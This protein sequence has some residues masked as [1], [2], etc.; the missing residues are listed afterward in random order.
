MTLLP[1]ASGIGGKDLVRS[2]GDPLHV[3][4]A[5]RGAHPGSKPHEDQV[6]AVQVRVRAP[7]GS[8]ERGR[9]DPCRRTALRCP[10]R[11]GRRRSCC[12]PPPGTWR[13][14][15]S[16]SGWAG[17]R[18]GRP[19]GPVAR[20]R[21]CRRRACASTVK[22]GCDPSTIWLLASRPCPDR[23]GG[24]TCGMRAS[25]EDGDGLAVDL[26][27]GVVDAASRRRRRGRGSSSVRACGGTS[28]L[29]LSA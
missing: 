11:C 25:P 16:P 8:L 20:R 7:H 3:G 29:G 12:N 5:G 17:C 27:V 28:L 21:P 19:G 9:Q 4:S 22:R 2:V 13:S 1:A 18:A 24:D 6:R 10:S 23:I 26:G 15:R 14:R